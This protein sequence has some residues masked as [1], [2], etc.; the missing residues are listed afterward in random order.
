MIWSD[1]LWAN[2]RGDLVKK[3]GKISYI[4]SILVYLFPACVAGRRRLVFFRLVFIDFKISAFAL[5]NLW[6]LSW[7]IFFVPL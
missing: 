5:R 2:C 6:V 1:T 4:S 3:T 7:L